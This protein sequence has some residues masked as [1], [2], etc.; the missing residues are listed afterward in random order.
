MVWVTVAVTVTVGLNVPL[1][2]VTEVVG[3]F[4]NTP[5]G[6]GPPTPYGEI[7]FRALLMAVAVPDPVMVEVKA[8]FVTRGV[9]TVEADTECVLVDE[10][11]GPMVMVG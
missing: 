9:L 7:E 11:E 4:T 3:V 2:P 6:V 8:K 5:L 10:K 1:P